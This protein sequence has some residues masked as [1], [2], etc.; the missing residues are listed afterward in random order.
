MSSRTWGDTAQDGIFTET[1]WP[2]ASGIA[3]QVCTPRV[4]RQEQVPEKASQSSPASLVLG[5]WPQPGLHLPP[6]SQWLCSPTQPRWLTWG[7]CW[8]AS[9]AAGHLSPH[10][11]LQ[12]AFNQW[13]LISSCGPP[14]AACWA[15]RGLR[16]QDL[17]GQLSTPLHSL[18]ATGTHAPVFTDW[19]A[20]SQELD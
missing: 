6:G 18:T 17:C 13:P 2:G 9:W 10:R 14:P 16:L 3:A 1:L 7:R 4:S 12:E 8:L 15:T 19:K 11:L 20:G 5:C